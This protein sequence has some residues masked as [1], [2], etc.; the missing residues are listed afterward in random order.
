MILKPLH[1]NACS[2][3]LCNFESDSNVTIVSDLQLEKQLIIDTESD[4]DIHARWAAPG[5]KSS[6]RKISITPLHTD[7]LR[8]NAVRTLI[9]LFSEAHWC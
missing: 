8:E 9:V 5:R 4:Y 1:S 2:S 6:W 7:I 3:I